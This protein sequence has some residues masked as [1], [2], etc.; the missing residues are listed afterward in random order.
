MATV[1]TGAASS[2]TAINALVD[3]RYE[4]KGNLFVGDDQGIWIY[5]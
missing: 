3:D 5:S 1:S 2:D 4:A